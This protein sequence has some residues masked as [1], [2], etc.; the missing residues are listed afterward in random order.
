MSG[1]REQLHHL[2]DRLSE[3]KLGPLLRL[4][5]SELG[6]EPVA[7]DLPFIGTLEA[8]PDFAERSEGIL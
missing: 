6:D 2:V 8:S 4:V 3:E 7:R 1:M 5:Q